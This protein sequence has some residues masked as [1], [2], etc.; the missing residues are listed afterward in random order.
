MEVYLTA[1]LELTAKWRRESPV[2]DTTPR[3]GYKNRFRNNYLVRYNVRHRLRI[4]Q[5]IQQ[6]HPFSFVSKSL[7]L[8]TIH[9]KYN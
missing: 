4:G 2:E 3:Q 1:E 6:D 5:M 9:V 8:I 7:F